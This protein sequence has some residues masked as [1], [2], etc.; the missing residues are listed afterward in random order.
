MTE[1]EIMEWME[2]KVQTEGFSDAAALAKEFLQSHSITNSTD[3]DFP[4]VL[5]A[6]FKIAQQV[7]DF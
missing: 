4:K 1:K 6:G 7:Y 3:P 2:K 5:D